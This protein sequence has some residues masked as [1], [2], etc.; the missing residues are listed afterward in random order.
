M[1]LW[2]LAG[3]KLAV[4]TGHQGNVND[5]SF[6]PDASQLVSVGDDGTWRLWAIGNLDETSSSKA[7]D[8]PIVTV[9]SPEKK[10]IWGVSFSPNGKTIAIVG[11]NGLAQLQN[12][13]GKFVTKFNT[14]SNRINNGNRSVSFSNDGQ[15]IGI[16]GDD[17][18]AKVFSLTGQLLNTFP[19][20]EKG[21]T[22][23][24]FSAD[25]KKVLTTDPQG[26]VRVWNR[27]SQSSQSDKPLKQFQAHDT[28]ITTAQVFRDR[29]P[30]A[31]SFATAGNDGEVRI[32][33]LD[34]AAYQIGTGSVGWE[35]CIV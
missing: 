19:D 26:L 35:S 13:N 1:K 22:T 17:T 24:Q 7:I 27:S 12:T 14:S 20:H 9:T 5:L 3:K 2:T 8:K 23:V 18:R 32:W 6:S 10:Q 30:Q 15:A 21:V 16:A 4:L 29:P 11:E 33:S 34:G 25:N 31:R 28:E